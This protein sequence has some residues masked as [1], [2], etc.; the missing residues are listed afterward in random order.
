MCNAI[1]WL[2]HHQKSQIIL[3]VSWKEKKMSA[4]ELHK[5]KDTFVLHYLISSQ[6]LMLVLWDSTKMK[7]NSMHSKINFEI[8]KP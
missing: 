1:I 3:L 5:R 8:A 4:L 2:F 6:G 7:T